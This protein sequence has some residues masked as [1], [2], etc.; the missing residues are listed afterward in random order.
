MSIKKK[1]FTTRT[2]AQAAIIA[3]VYAVLTVP[4]PLAF[5][6]VQVRFSE[7]L[8]ILPLFTP[9]AIP[10]LFAGVLIS[11]IIAGYGWIDMIFGSLATLIAAWMTYAIGRKLLSTAVESNIFEKWEILKFHIAVFPPIIVNAVVVGFYLYMFIFPGEYALWFAMGFVGLGQVIA[12][13]GLGA[14]LYNALK[15]TKGKFYA[16]N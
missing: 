1:F 8:T 12:C 13:Y 3:A 7:A 5:G 16:K 4:N 15:K 11:N 10:G 9:V 14:V 6:V 2:L